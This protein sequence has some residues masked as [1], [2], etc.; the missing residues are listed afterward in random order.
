MFRSQR[1]GH[2]L[3]AAVVVFALAVV[4][5][6]PCVDGEFLNWDDDKGITDNYA[7]RGLDRGALG[8][9]FSTGHMGHYQPLSWLTLALDAELSGLE[10]PEYRQA[11]AFH[12][13]SL[14]LHGLGAVALLLLALRLFARAGVGA[15]PVWCAGFAAAFWAVHP[16]RCES[17]CWITER[18]DVLSAPLL[19]LAAWAWLRAQPDE[20]GGARLCAGA[21]WLAAATAA[22][23]VAAF[24]GGVD[25]DP[26]AGR[27]AVRSVVLLCSAVVLLA[28]STWAA[29]LAVSPDA[30]R[31][32]GWH[33]LAVSL[34]AVS[35]LAKAWGI[36]L[37]LL[38]L[39]LD[40]WPL[41]RL[42]EW[43]GRVAAVVEKLPM[44]ALGVV[45]ASTA[46]WAQATQGANMLSWEEH[47]ALERLAQA[48]YGLVFYPAVTLLPV[49]LSPIY[50]LPPE[51]SFAEARFA[52]PAVVVAVAAILLLAFARRAPALLA[53]ALAYGI[54]VAP[55]LGFQ[56]SGPQLVA[57]RYLYIAGVPFALLAG[58]AVAACQAKWRRAPLVLAVVAILALGV[59]T[60]DQSRI[61]RSSLDLWTHAHALEPRNATVCFHF[62]VAKRQAALVEPDFNRARQLLEEAEQL[63]LRGL[64][65]HPEDPGFLSNLGNVHG[66]LARLTRGAER[67]RHLQA[68]VERSREALELATALGYPL[69]DYLLNCGAALQ[70]AG[71]FA[72]AERLLEQT[73]QR[74]PFLVEVRLALVQLLE[75]GSRGLDRSDPA[76]ALEK[77]QRIETHLAEV[78]AREPGFEPQRVQLAGVLLR[79]WKCMTA[80]GS[81][82]ADAVRRAAVQLHRELLA[83]YPGEQVLRQ[84]LSEL[85]GG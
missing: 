80:L 36:A 23:A 26:E 11:P 85:G 39:V 25:L 64:E 65:T 50:A 14:V 6:V 53:A 7:F 51:L 1:T 81:E 82:G 58:G 43:R 32:R 8:W 37:P 54:A 56:Q 27:L 2:V 21:A 84:Q 19:F 24:F 40:G 72:E 70:Q 63:Y 52:V 22:G 73:L 77:L 17:V 34:L 47:T 45:F 76:S 60:W 9:M 68:A 79:K 57:D 5:F 55:V 31:R 71:R 28:A 15:A 16:L 74:A 38:L 30:V 62:G 78:L 75:Q 20:P 41:R 33:A 35:L 4:P 46:R 61:W 44:L 3:L 29:G 67:D 13:T 12:R 42:G 83:R 18:R 69:T 49:G 66:S 48:A 10:G 59:R